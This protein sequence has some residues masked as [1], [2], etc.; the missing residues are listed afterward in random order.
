MIHSQTIS[1]E[2]DWIG[3]THQ[4]P[5]PLTICEAEIFMARLKEL[6]ES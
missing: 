1:R 2:K 6:R 3:Q 5:M 4:M